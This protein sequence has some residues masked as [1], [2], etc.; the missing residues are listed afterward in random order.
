MF[1][2][3][4]KKSVSHHM[5]VNPPE[6]FSVLE[7][8]AGASEQQLVYRESLK[9]KAI[10]TR[11]I[12]AKEALWLPR[13][14]KVREILQKQSNPFDEYGVEWSVGN[15]LCFLFPPKYRELQ[16]K[17]SV[18]FIEF[19]CEHGGQVD[20]REISAFVERSGVS[21]ATF[22]NKIIPRLKHAGLIE[23]K[24]P[25]RT[26]ARESEKGPMRVLLSETFHNYLFKMAKEW[27]RIVLTARS[28]KE[29]QT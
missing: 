19:V 25:Q 6:V 17:H 14:D 5:N 2:N 7:A 27:R 13:H 16:Y 28:K 29:Q 8:S 10:K 12:P 1:F 24:R 20:Y 23:V 4:F 9:G 3:Q 11:G 18:A 26:G 22:Y 15:V 21:K